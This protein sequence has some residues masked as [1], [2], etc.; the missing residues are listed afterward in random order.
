MFGPEGF[1]GIR[2]DAGEITALGGAKVAII[3]RWQ[4]RREGTRSDG[5][6]MLTFKAWFSWKQ[7]ALMKMC[8]RGDLKGRVR[9]QM[10]TKVGLE[11]VD[12]VH[13]DEWQLNDDGMLT[14][15][16]IV[17]FDTQPIK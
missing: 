16:N 7:D 4:I 3:A 9:V 13:W 1:G 17:H 15:R 14:L 12:V 6:P 11:N 2:G 10:K 5:K 8:Q